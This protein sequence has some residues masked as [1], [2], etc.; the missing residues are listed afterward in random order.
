MSHGMTALCSAM[1][2]AP[3]IPTVRGRSRTSAAI[4]IMHQP[5]TQMTPASM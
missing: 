2:R 3:M 5:I 1:I 4:R